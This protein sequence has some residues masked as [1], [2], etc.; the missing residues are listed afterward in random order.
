M[1]F[2]G[3]SP[4]STLATGISFEVSHPSP[5]L[6]AN[7]HCAPSDE[8]DANVLENVTKDEVL[9]LFLSKVHQSSSSR[10][11]LSVHMISQK[12]HS[13]HVSAKAAEVFISEVATRIPGVDA[14]AWRAE[15]DEKPLLQD[16]ATY[17][18]GKIGD[19]D[20]GKT[21]LERLPEIVKDHPAEGESQHY[22]KP[23][24]KYIEDLAQF[25][26]TL[27]PSVDP[28]P[29]VDWNDLPISRF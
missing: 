9:S 3:S 4:I 20:A 1:R 25:K 18:S 23:S 15:L 17:W 19:S 16:F 10:G 26:G 28:G 22:S 29:M 5:S 7:P 27:Q 2:Q 21:V 8:N 13:K 11:K 24:A 12:A 6:W 14:Q